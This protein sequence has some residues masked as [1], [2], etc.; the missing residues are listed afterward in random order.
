M[1]EL[2]FETVKSTCQYGSWELIADGIVDLSFMLLDINPGLGGKPDPRLR[3]SW[4]LAHE[5][6]N[7]VVK[8]KLGVAE[9][10]IKQLSKRIMFSKGGSKYTDCLKSVIVQA[11]GELMNKTSVLN[12][13]LQHISNLN[14]A[15]GKRVLLSLVPIIKISTPFRY[16]SLKL[17]LSFTILTCF[18]F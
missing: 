8:T 10:I 1:K 13:I 7:L 18:Q 17:Q 9:I 4:N 14:Y 2:L 5:I 6:L 11:Q 15:G 3:Q 12:E 16:V